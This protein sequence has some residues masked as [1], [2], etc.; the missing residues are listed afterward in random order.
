MLYM[1]IY[2]ALFLIDYENGNQ[3]EINDN[4]IIIDIGTDY[5]TVY[6]NVLKF[7]LNKK[8]NNG[9][10]EIDDNIIFK[11]MYDFV[12]CGYKILIISKEI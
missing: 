2:V 8:L 11:E 10:T 6:N 4:E 12:Y 5:D 9:I 1:N 7:K 3:C